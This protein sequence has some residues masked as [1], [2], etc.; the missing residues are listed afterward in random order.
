[1]KLVLKDIEVN[2]EFLELRS[3]K[4]MTVNQYRYSMR[5]GDTFPK[6]IVDQINTIVSGHHRYESMLQEFGEDY[7]ID[8]IQKKFKT[9]KEKLEF[10]TKENLKHGLILQEFEKK[11]IFHKFVYEHGA[12]K[13]ELSKIFNVSVKKIFKWEGDV[14]IVQIGGGKE[15]KLMPTKR[16]LKTTKPITEEQYA[17]H[18]IKDGGVTISFNVNQVIRWLK[19]GFIEKTDKNIELMEKLSIEINNWIKEK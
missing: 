3:I 6:I 4:Q 2:Q 11:K 18:T 17:E 19:N 7:E 16:G 1:M 15:T 10:F 12:T 13:E 8:V 5:Q 9:N 14:V